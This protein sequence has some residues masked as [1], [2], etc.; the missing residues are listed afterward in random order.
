MARGK[1][2]RM[3]RRRLKGGGSHHFLE[4]ETV[5]LN[6]KREIIGPHSPRATPTIRRQTPEAKYENFV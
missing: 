4:S 6:E 1:Y 2:V 3:A 5:R